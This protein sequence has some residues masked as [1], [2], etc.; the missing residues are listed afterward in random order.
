VPDDE[1]PRR[2]IDVLVVDDHPIMRWGIV[3]VLEECGYCRVV[4]ERTDGAEAPQAVVELN[5]DVVVMDVAMA[6]VDGITATALVRDVKPEVQVIVTS[7]ERDDERRAAAKAAGAYAFVSKGDPASQL[8]T[9][10]REAVGR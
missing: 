4:G 8:V 7:A 5:P 3:T 2:L 1:P 9:A 10:I 6:R